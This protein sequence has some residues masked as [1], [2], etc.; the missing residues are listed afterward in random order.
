M[1][2]PYHCFQILTTESPLYLDPSWLLFVDF[3]P[4]WAFQF[5][6]KKLEFPIFQLQAPAHPCY[7][8]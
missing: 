6:V 4:H 1:N 2:R 8:S 3:E 7:Q 5:P